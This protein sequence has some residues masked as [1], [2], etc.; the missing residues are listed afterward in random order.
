M[1]TGFLHN[2][3]EYNFSFN[4][5][6]LVY[7]RVHVYVF[8]YRILK[9]TLKASGSNATKSHI[10]QV[11]LSA[12][13]L[14]NACKLADSMFG[15]SRCTQHTTAD[16]ANDISK[17]AEQLRKCMVTT[18]MVDW[19]I[20][21]A[22]DFQEPLSKGMAKISQGWLQDFIQRTDTDDSN[23]SDR[24]DFE[25]DREELDINYELYNNV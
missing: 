9:Q 11:S 21:D 8:C 22:V 1:F 20:H 7:V 4:V 18:E 24:D 13:C 10:E 3:F 17:M 25:I 23:D 16:A 15:V 19:S 6:I 14:L 12:L 2:Q 5:Y